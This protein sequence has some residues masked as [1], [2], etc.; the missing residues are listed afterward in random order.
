MHPDITSEMHHE[1]SKIQGSGQHKLLYLKA[2]WMK[3]MSMGMVSNRKYTQDSLLSLD[4]FTSQINAVFLAV[5]D[6][7]CF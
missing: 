5:F 1:V 2:L 6:I 4:Y 7:L 3:E